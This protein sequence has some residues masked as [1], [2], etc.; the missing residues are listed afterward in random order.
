MYVYENF[1]FV[2]VFLFLWFSLLFFLVHLKQFLAEQLLLSAFFFFFRSSD[3]FFCHHPFW[4]ALCSVAIKKTYKKM[5]QKWMLKA[6]PRHTYTTQIRNY[7]LYKYKGA[8]GRERET[9]CKIEKKKKRKKTRQNAKAHSLMK[10]PSCD[11]ICLFSFV[12]TCKYMKNE[13]QSRPPR[14]RWAYSLD[15]KQ[16]LQWIKRSTSIRLR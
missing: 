2:L 13:R 10:L 4:F 7:S 6:T 15:L 8:G 16:Q 14:Y 1:P 5:N 3:F 11:E 9:Y 12:H